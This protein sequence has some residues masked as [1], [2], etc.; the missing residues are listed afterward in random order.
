[1]TFEDFWGLYPRKVAKLE[2][3]KAW[4]QMVRQFDPKEIIAGLERN[5]PALQSKDRQYVKHPASWLRAGCWM[6]E[7][8]TERPRN[9][10]D[11]ARK[12]LN[13][14]ERIFSNRDDVQFVSGWQRG[15]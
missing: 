1:M 5:L 8:E 6:D 10:A 14:P 11:A 13:G 7:P 15:H 4:N 12:I 2:A 9:Y 3:V